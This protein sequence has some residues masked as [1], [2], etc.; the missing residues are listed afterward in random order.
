MAI[1]RVMTVPTTTAA[2]GE[3]GVIK[4]L[5]VFLHVCVVYSQV[6]MDIG[7]IL[8]ANVGEYLFYTLANI[9]MLHGRVLP[10]IGC[11]HWPCD[12]GPMFASDIGA[13]LLTDIG[14]HWF[15]SVGQ[16]FIHWYNI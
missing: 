6:T 10:N 14:Q 2:H 12:I 1:T 13:K 9:G 5:C 11:Q 3:S 16:C 7:Q 8:D 4:T 15:V